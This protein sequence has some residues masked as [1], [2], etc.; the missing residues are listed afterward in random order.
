MPRVGS[1]KFTSF[2]VVATVIVCAGLS[3]APARGMA[4][5]APVPAQ[6]PIK[7]EAWQIRRLE[8]L[9]LIKDALAP[10]AAK[11]QAFDQ[12]LT[13]F[14]AH[15]LAQTPI[16]NMDLLGLSMRETMGLPNLSR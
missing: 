6:R 8:R 15:P 12:L 7:L 5:G 11:S 2:V 14:E 10:N 9:K 3:L 1:S 4:Q 16:E 13:N